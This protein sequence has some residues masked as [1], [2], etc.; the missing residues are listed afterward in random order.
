MGFEPSGIGYLKIAHLRGLGTINIEEMDIYE[1][2]SEGVKPCEDIGK[3][4]SPIPFE[5]LASDKH[6]RDIPLNQEMLLRCQIAV[7]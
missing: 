7:K 3:F 6:A 2:S 5:V 4:M 1:V